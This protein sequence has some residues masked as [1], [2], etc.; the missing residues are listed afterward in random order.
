MDIP[1]A[2]IGKAK[3]PAATE[4]TAALDSSAG[5]WKQ[6]VAWLAEEHGVNVQEWKSISPKFGWSL[7]LKRKKRT[8][9]HL[10][11]C[12]HCF[13]VTIILGS[14]AVKTARQSS[15]PKSVIQ[16]IF[17]APRHTEGTGVRLV[18]KRTA[19]LPAIHKLVAIKLAS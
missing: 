4:L 1:N 14:K 18:V 10:S 5:A 12:N 3:K 19:D 7:Q 2:F 13:R 16:A 6:F 9:V 8:I 17:D 11:P 15:L